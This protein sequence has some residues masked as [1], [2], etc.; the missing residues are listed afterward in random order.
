[1]YLYSFTLLGLSYSCEE[2]EH[3]MTGGT[4]FDLIAQKCIDRQLLMTGCED[5][6]FHINWLQD[7]KKKEGKELVL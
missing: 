3:S 6:L 4:H 7:G 1:M 5:I 2:H